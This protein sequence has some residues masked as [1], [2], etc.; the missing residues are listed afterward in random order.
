MFKG[1]IKAS[2]SDFVRKLGI[3]KGLEPGANH[4]GVG[5]VIDGLAGRRGARGDGRALY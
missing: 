2:T 1:L 4:T 5:A 3:R